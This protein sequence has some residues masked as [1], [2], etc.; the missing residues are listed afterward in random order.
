MSTGWHLDPNDGHW[1][2]L[3]PETGKMAKG[4]VLIDGKW[5]YFTT[6]NNQDTY[7]WQDGKWLYLDNN[8]RPLG[9]M[10]AGEV[11]PDGYTLNSD[12]SW[13]N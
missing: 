3:D 6:Q 11:T 12:G 8:A 13:A 2:Y 7:T 4:W 9:S 5:Y 1:Y 10:Y